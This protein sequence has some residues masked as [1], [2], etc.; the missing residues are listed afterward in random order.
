MPRNAEAGPLKVPCRGR[1]FRWSH[2]TATRMRL[3]FPTMLFVGSKS[4]HPAPGKYAC[5]HACVFPPPTAAV[6]R[7][8]TKMYPLTKRAA[9]PSRANGFHHEHGEV[10][11]APAAAPKRLG[12]CLDTLLG[13][14]QIRE[15]F[16][17]A[18]RHRMEQAHRRRRSRRRCQEALDPP[19]YVVGRILAR[20]SVDEVGP[21]VIRIAKRESVRATLECIVGKRRL[22]MFEGGRAVETK[23]GRRGVER[24][25]GHRVVEDVM[26]PPEAR[27]A[28]AG[29]PAS[30]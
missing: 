13:T 24:C 8:G 29:C 7:S 18:A 5:S 14:P 10:P 3:R 12:R 9:R 25:D 28:A 16:I 17:D 6:P 23:L 4:T 11:T 21:F 22:Q 20:E 2:A 30:C 27:M 15:L 19:I 26:K 1:A